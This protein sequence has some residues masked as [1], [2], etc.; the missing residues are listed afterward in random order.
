MFHW[1]FSFFIPLQAK[2]ELNDLISRLRSRDQYRHTSLVSQRITQTLRHFFKI[3]ILK[4]FFIIHSFNVLQAF[5]GLGILT[6]YTVDVLSKTRKVGTEIL[7]DYSA[8]VVISGVRVVTVLASSFLMLK[9]GRRTIAMVSGIFSSA[10]ALCLAIVLSLNNMESGS[11]ISPQLEANITF[12]SILIYAG[13]MSFGFF[14]LPSIMIGE[15]QPSHVR[16]FAC[17]YIY[18]MNDLL[19][20]SVVKMYPW[21]L[22]NLQ[23]HGLFLFFGISCVVCTTFVY[24]FLPET[25]GL[26]LQQIE[27]YF[28]QPNIMWV[29]R[30]KYANETQD[31]DVDFSS[32]ATHESS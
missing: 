22:S 10:S 30:N 28:R 11:P 16:G 2:D 7:D 12:T 25:Q 9:I 13:S 32:M 15:T 19:L 8:T 23:M 24:L 27:D 31:Q 5:C 17:G 4:P 20:G 1:T 21:M 26:T 29:T 3:R 14:A 18:T 6:Y